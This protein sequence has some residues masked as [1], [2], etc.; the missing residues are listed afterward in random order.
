MSTLFFIS[1]VITLFHTLFGLI[2]PLIKPRSN[3]TEGTSNASSPLV[4]MDLNNARN[5]R[6]LYSSWREAYINTTVSWTFLFTRQICCLIHTFT[7]LVIYY[8]DLDIALVCRQVLVATFYIVICS[9]LYLVNLISLAPLNIC[10]VNY[11]FKS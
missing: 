3:V 8:Q 1:G 4:N 5:K 11:L 7:L 2:W 10:Y 6:S 9:Y